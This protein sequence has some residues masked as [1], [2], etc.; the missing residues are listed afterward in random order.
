MGKG[1]GVLEFFKPPVPMGEVGGR[2]S[3]CSSLWARRREG[4]TLYIQCSYARRV[5]GRDT[6][7]WCLLKD[8]GCEKIVN[9]YSEYTASKSLQDRVSIETNAQRIPIVTMKQLQISDSGVYWCAGGSGL[10][11]TLEVVLSVFK[12]EYLTCSQ[13]P[14]VGS[15][16][17]HCP[18]VGSCCPLTAPPGSQVCP[19]DTHLSPCPSLQG[20]QD[21]KF[22]APLHGESGCSPLL[23]R[24]GVEVEVWR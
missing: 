3:L 7:Y 13:C 18:G 10:T 12:S 24:G 14:G 1:F 15:C 2:V 8:G 16:C 4:G 17:T 23:L 6:K 22:M 5:A 11:R 21:P 19:G 9:T 20:G